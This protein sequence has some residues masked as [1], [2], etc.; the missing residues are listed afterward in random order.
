MINTV[1]CVTATEDSPK[2]L[3]SLFE[4]IHSTQLPRVGNK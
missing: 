3:N 2:L 1:G 4:L